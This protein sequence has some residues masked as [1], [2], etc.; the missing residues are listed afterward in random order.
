MLFSGSQFAPGSALVEQSVQQVFQ[1]GP[2]TVELYAEHLDA[3]RFPEEH[4]YRL[5]REYLQAKY[6]QNPPDVIVTFLI[7]KFELAGRLPAELFPGIPVV[8]GALTEEAVPAE[9]FG[10]Q[11]TGVIQRMDFPGALELILKLQPET[12]RIV[13]IGGTAQLDR[14]YLGRTEEAA[15]SLAGRVQFDYWTMRSVAEMRQAVASLP[16]RT[17]IFFTTVFRDAT[18]KS[19][20]P[21]AVASTLAASSSVPIYVVAD[22]L[23]GGG[24]VG[25]FV[26]HLEALGRRLGELAQQVLGGTAPASLPLEVRTDGVPMFDWRE[27]K[28]WGI[29]ESRLPPGSVVRFRLPSMWEEYRWTITGALVIIAVQAVLISGL[30]LQRAR[31]RRAESELRESQQLMEL[32]TSANELGLWVRDPEQGD[33]WASPSLR[34]LFGLGEKDALRFND[35]IGQIHPDDKPRIV[36]AVAHAQQNGVRF[37]EEFRIVLSDGEERWVA[38]RGA[39]MN[40]PKEGSIRRMGAVFDITERKHAQYELDRHRDELAHAGRVSI[41]GQLASALAHELNQPLGAILRNA[42][43]ATLFLQA[44]PPDLQEVA[45]ILADICKDDQRAGEVIDRMRALLKRREFQWSDLDLNALAEEVASLVRPDAETRKVTLALDLAPTVLPV[46]GDRV[47]LQQVLLNILLNAMD[48][49]SGSGREERRVS[50]RTQLVDGQAEVAVSDAGHGIPAEDLK[51]LFDPFFTTK[52]NGM[53]MGL[54]I[55]QTIIGVH[56]GRIVAEN[57]ADRGAT[58]RITL[59]MNS[60]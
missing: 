30:L 46:R 21:A 5:F 56:G 9:G 33:F 19:F 7:V 11:V 27:L 57:N 48:A 29:S 12:E 35:I 4:H 8:L 59:P 51:H 6:A 3:N 16:P 44:S 53:G 22:S 25:G 54:A 24:T 18:G 23:I 42:E 58:F 15:R 32:A 20:L 10:D 37:E 14:R 2:Q 13:V 55:S 1:K 41:M 50:V 36:S 49:L 28:R 38:A 52:P 17:V 45:A 34:S 47:Q 43:A 40:E 60:E 31:R 26:A 39:G